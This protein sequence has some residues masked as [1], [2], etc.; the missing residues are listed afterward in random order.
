MRHPVMALATILAALG[1]AF[2]PAR[3]AE[4]Q[5][6]TAMPCLPKVQ[7]PLKADYGDLPAGTSA[8]AGQF[9][10]WT[11][12]TPGGYQSVVFLFTPSEVA[13][14][15]VQYLRGLM[16]LAQANAICASTCWTSL[17]AS[18]QAFVDTEAAK[19]AARAVVAFDPGK[20]TRATYATNADGT[21]NPT[22]V[23]TVSIGTACDP[24]QRIASAPSYYLVAP[25]Q[26]AVCVVS[27]PYGSN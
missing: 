22:P 23:N 12:E 9:V 10:A 15:A 6:L 4:A 8:R 3:P 5:A 27:L 24:S 13:A 2:M 25:G 14:N 26:Y 17:T 1:L 16:T 11:C 21:L 20:T 7:W 18:E 19:V